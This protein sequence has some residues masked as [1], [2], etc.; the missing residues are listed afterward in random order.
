MLKKCLCLLILMGMMVV[1]T[2]HSTSFAQTG[3][4]AVVAYNNLNVRIGPHDEAEIV[5]QL[6]M[7][8]DVTIH[9]KEDF[10]RNGG[11][12]VYV[13]SGGLTGWVRSDFLAWDA[14]LVWDTIPVGYGDGA[15]AY[16]AEIFALARQTLD[17][18]AEPQWNAA[19]GA[20]IAVGE[21]VAV[22]GQEDL[23]GRGAW[24]LVTGLRSGASGWVED[25]TLMYPDSMRRPTAWSYNLPIV[26]P[27]PDGTLAEPIL[28]QV[29]GFIIWRSYRSRA[30]IRE[31]PDANSPI[32]HE[33][34]RGGGMLLAV[35]G[36]S[37]DGEWVYVTQVRGDVAGWLFR[38]YARDSLPVLDSVVNPTLPP[39]P[40]P[41]YEI[42]A[43]VS[44][45]R[46][47]LR[48]QPSSY[49][50]VAVWI[51][52]GTELVVIGRN[53]TNEYLMTEYDGQVGWVSRR[54]LS[55]EGNIGLLP[56]WSLRW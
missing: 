53:I 52:R 39:P 54:E 45:Y 9:M 55:Y 25:Q 47:R 24:L 7:D 29:G 37:A 42:P 26:L 17:L 56:V 48:R 32:V 27:H 51:P 33:L 16:D 13:T 31:L 1:Y 6:M 12:W 49:Y 21:L 28:P 18:R 40:E 46:A 14:S 41:I 34:G 23:S 43:T 20:S 4:Q 10:S 15:N 3:G 30:R 8:M 11:L 36:R 5:G 44:V 19:S 22:H 50:P 35:H 38:W 2:P